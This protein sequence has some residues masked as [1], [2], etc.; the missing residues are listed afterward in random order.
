MDGIDDFAAL[1][2]TMVYRQVLTV[3]SPVIPASLRRR[4]TRLYPSMHRSV[5]AEA[6]VKASTA[7][8]PGGGSMASPRQPSGPGRLELVGSLPDFPSG[9][10]F[11]RPS[12]ASSVSNGPEVCFSSVSEKSQELSDISSFESSRSSDVSSPM[13]S[14]Y[15]AD[16]GLRWNRIVPAL[17]LLQNA[18]HEA[19]QRQCDSRL[20]RILYVD[21]LGYLLDGL[22][23]DMNDQET[24]KIQNKLPTSV[25]ESLAAPVM[26]ELPAAG[27]H[28]LPAGENSLPER[29]YL[30]RFLSSTIIYFFIMLQILMPYV[31]VLMRHLYQYERSHRVTERAVTKVL[32]AA[33]NFGK[34][35]IVIGAAVLN[36]N[37]GR[38]G[39]IIFD[40]AS[41]WVTGIVGGIC[42]GFAEGM[43]IM[44]ITRSHV[45]MMRA[46][47]QAS[48]R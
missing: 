35:G 14:K 43:I 30:H 5:R 19:Q 15:E 6:G 2:D 44:G 18:C 21:A 9:P 16:S 42:E 29:S 3:F 48:R 40:L 25:K 34:R 7:G 39:A 4:I 23:E 28:S 38:V 1:S 27:P 22:P 13:A 41:W 12:T 45:E 36:Y 11:Q 46:F 10:T 33:D 8:K 37:E 17:N 32:G 26:T 24:T 20:A 31:K 47:V